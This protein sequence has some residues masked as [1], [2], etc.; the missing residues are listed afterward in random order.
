MAFACIFGQD[1]SMPPERPFR[2]RKNRLAVVLSRSISVPV[3]TTVGVGPS[4]IEREDPGTRCIVT[5][6]QE[7]RRVN[8]ERREAH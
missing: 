6:D 4:D 2:G 8:S 1:G 7:I 3:D 5:G